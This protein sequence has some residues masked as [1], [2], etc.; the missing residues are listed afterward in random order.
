VQVLDRRA[1][2]HAAP[3]TEEAVVAEADR[4]AIEAV[5]RNE[6]ARAAQVR[7]ERK[8]A[9]AK[10]AGDAAR[11]ATEAVR[12]IRSAGLAAAVKRLDE[13]RALEQS[14]QS[15]KIPSADMMA[16]LR[17]DHDGAAGSI[18]PPYAPSVPPSML[19]PQPPSYAPPAPPP[20]APLP[21]VARGVD[22]RL[23]TFAQPVASPPTH[24]DPPYPPARPVPPAPPPPAPATVDVDAFAA[25]LK[26]SILG[27]P[28]PAFAAVVVVG[29]GVLLVLILLL[30]K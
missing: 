27:L 10:L 25:N 2:Q 1:F 28:V 18:R 14:L 11:I 8:I 23:P 15:G 20:L 24:P 12:I 17:V 9:A 26:P 16:V 22:P 29:L 6:E 5:R 13:A 30:A 4:L 3:M 19:P 7:A 21:S